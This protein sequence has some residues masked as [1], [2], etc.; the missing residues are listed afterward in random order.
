MVK[1]LLM[2]L[3]L[4]VL[5]LAPAT[6]VTQIAVSPSRPAATAPVQTLP[7]VAAGSNSAPDLGIGEIMAA[8]GGLVALGLVRAVGRQPHSVSA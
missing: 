5:P 3:V 4:A 6:A 8:L 7:V 1:Y 2:T